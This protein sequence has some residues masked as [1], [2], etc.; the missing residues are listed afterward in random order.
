MLFRVI[1]FSV[2]FLMIR[3][4]PRSTRTDTLFPYTTLFRSIDAYL[5]RH[6]ERQIARHRP[7]QLEQPAL[8]RLDQPGQFRLIEIDVEEPFVIL[9]R[10]LIDDL[11]KALGGAELR[12]EIAR[13]GIGPP[14]DEGADRLEEIRV[15]DQLAQRVRDPASLG[16][17]IAARP[18]GIGIDGFFRALLPGDQRLLVTDSS[19]LRL[20]L[21]HVIDQIGRAHV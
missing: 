21:R 4:P 1:T 18:R 13:S 9:T 10:H 19:A 11:E 20:E 12:P 7:A 5:Y 3:R 15:A 2:F 14:I 16:I 17:D 8:T 6:R